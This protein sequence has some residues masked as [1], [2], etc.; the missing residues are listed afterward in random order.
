ML[1]DYDTVQFYQ[2]SHSWGTVHTYPDIFE[3]GDFFLRLHLPST[4]KQH[5]RP[6][7]GGNIEDP[8]PGFMIRNK[9]KRSLVK[10]FKNYELSTD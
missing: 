5:F 4:G 3:N 7:I 2:Q 8:L 1:D 10:G 9:Y 6:Q